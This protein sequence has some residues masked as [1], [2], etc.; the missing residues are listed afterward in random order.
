[1]RNPFDDQWLTDLYEMVD[2]EGLSGYLE[3]FH[4]IP[5]ADRWDDYVLRCRREGVYP[6]DPV[7][8]PS[9]V[10][11]GNAIGASRGGVCG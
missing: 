6:D 8:P 2:R 9:P 5:L 3:D 7:H 1:M 11:L 10:G 4:L